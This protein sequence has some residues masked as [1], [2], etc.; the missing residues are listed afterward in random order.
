[1]NINNLKVL[2]AGILIC[3]GCG[4]PDTSANQV[5]FE[6]SCF[7]VETASTP[8]QRSLGLMHR[9]SLD[10]DK[11]MLFIFQ[12]AQAYSFWMKNTLIPLDI[13]WLDY[14]RRIVHIEKNVTPCEHDPCANYRPL[15]GALYVLEINAGLADRFNIQLGDVAEFNLKQDQSK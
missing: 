1:M 2:I 11:G 10:Q 9:K 3:S 13:I 15:T 14:A 12:E 4:V 5:C 6:Q 8:E 7:L